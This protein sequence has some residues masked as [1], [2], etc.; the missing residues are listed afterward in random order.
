MRIGFQLQLSFVFF[1]RMISA[2]GDGLNVFYGV[3]SFNNF[4]YF[5]YP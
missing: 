5:L 1:K 3:I 2:I 4:L